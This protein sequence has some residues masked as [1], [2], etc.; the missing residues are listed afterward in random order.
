MS[1]EQT[2]ALP[3][4]TVRTGD[5]R[6]YY[7]LAQTALLL[8]LL[9][10]WQGVSDRWI[11]AFFISSPSA[12][13]VK[14]YTW[15]EDGTLW[16]AFLYTFQAMA[17]G[18]LLGS[19]FGFVVGFTLGRS[20]MLSRLLDQHQSIPMLDK[21][22]SDNREDAYC[23]LVVDGSLGNRKGILFKRRVLWHL[24]VLAKAKPFACVDVRCEQMERAYPLS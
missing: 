10:I 3:V 1:V 4:H 11:D 15:A 18:F 21:I 13:A 22:V 20:E 6:L 7:L 5:H 12:V 16:N 23:L 24:E 19:L 14:L 8:L 17:G 9:G 2:D